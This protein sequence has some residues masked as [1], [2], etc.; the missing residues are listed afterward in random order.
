MTLDVE[1]RIEGAGLGQEVREA[2]GLLLLC[3]GDRRWSIEPGPIVGHR[4]REVVTPIF[5][6]D[7]DLRGPGVAQ[8]IPKRFLHDTI[9]TDLDRVGK[10][11]VQT[12]DG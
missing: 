5:H 11:S 10:A 1:G 3:V 2:A 9:G 12:Q 4:H 7:H 8:R 6:R